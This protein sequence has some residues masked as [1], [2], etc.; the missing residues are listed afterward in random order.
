MSLCSS[1]R[2]VMSTGVQEWVFTSGQGKAQGR[3]T[4]ENW[5]GEYTCKC[6]LLILETCKLSVNEKEAIGD[7][8]SQRC[9][10][11]IYKRM[12]H[13]YNTT[14]CCCGYETT[15]RWASKGMNQK[16][17]MMRPACI[18]TCNNSWPSAWSCMEGGQGDVWMRPGHI[19]TL[20]DSNNRWWG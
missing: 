13:I 17:Y 11:S 16:E 19:N 4:Y 18:L 6:R 9:A 3:Q 14:K 12:K 7:G 20:V 15:E 2:V 5:T 10:Q 1:S 8:T